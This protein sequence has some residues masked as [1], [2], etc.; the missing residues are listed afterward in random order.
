MN[1]IVCSYVENSFCLVRDVTRKP[2]FGI[3]GLV[4]V[5]SHLK[6]MIQISTASGQYVCGRRHICDV[7]PCTGSIFEAWPHP[8]NNVMCS[9]LS[10]SL[11]FF[12]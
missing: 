8:N 6:P 1:A 10:L 11:S 9:G 4:S 2:W 12:F 7:E 5:S 3:C